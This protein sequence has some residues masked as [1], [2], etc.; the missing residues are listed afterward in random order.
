MFNDYLDYVI[1]NLE[2]G[3]LVYLLENE[4]AAQSA[5]VKCGVSRRMRPPGRAM[6]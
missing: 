6:R 5:F 4:E 1:N 3:E 2:I